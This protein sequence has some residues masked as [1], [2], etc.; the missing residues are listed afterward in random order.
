MARKTIKELE[1][2]I[3]TLEKQLRNSNKYNTD[4][5]NKIYEL[6]NKKDDN[7]KESNLYKQMEKIIERL[8]KVNEMYANN[9]PKAIVAGNVEEL[10]KL[11]ARNNIL[12]KKIDNL[13]IENADLK[14]KAEIEKNDIRRELEQ[15]KTK[16]NRATERNKAIINDYAKCSKINEQLKKQLQEVKQVGR[17][18][19]INDNTVQKVIELRKENKSIRAIAK[20]LNLSVGSVH[21]IIE[22]NKK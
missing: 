20:E 1:E 17:P 4:L 14:T 22:Q 8:K 5:R 3:S 9:K 10:E 13:I 21:N 11:E 2:Y 16:L 15:F 19:R 6:E 7:F 12:E 18:K